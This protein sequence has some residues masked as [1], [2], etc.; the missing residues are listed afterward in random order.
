MRARAARAATAAKDRSG[1]FLSLLTLGFACGVT[2]VALGLLLGLQR[3]LPHCLFFL[4]ARDPGGFRRGGLGLKTF[5]LGL[6]RFLRLS[7][8]GSGSSLRFALG[9]AALHLRIVR[10]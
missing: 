2:G 7:C 10:A 3:C 9:L 8:L 6:R 4:L 1:R 5:L